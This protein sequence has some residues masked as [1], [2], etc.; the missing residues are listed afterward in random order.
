[1]P[2]MPSNPEQEDRIFE[3]LMQDPEVK[4]HIE[5]LDKEAQFRKKLVQARKNA[6]FQ[7]KTVGMLTGLDQRAIS[8]VE[9]NKAI[10]PNLRTLVKYLSAIGYELD[11]RKVVAE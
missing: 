4:Q 7:Q 2:F 5:E 11:I 3:E 8:R 6:G 10:S 9:T 1:M